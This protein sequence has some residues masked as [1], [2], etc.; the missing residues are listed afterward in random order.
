MNREELYDRQRELFGQYLKIGT[1]VQLLGGIIQNPLDE[2]PVTDDRAVEWLEMTNEALRS[3]RMLKTRTV[4][5]LRDQGV[6]IL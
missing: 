5:L 1:D 2:F 3:L 6:I 4:F